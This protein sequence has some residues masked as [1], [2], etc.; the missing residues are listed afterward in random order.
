MPFVCLPRIS[1][2]LLTAALFLLVSPSSFSEEAV[3]EGLTRILMVEGHL[4]EPE[5][6]TVRP[7]EKILFINR[8]KDLHAL[9]L[10]GRED[11]L[12]EV[13][14]DPGQEHT[15]LIPADTPSGTLDLRC[16]IHID[17]TGKITVVRP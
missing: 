6:V 9:A 12:D 1:C 14:L 10:N 11:L 15:L 3:Q 4:F 5:S 7:G 17:M 8:D 16:T 2:V 13:Y